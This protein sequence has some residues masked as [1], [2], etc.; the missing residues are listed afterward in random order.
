M[1]REIHQL[2]EGYIT[3]FIVINFRGI[4][5]EARLN[6]MTEKLNNDK[7]LARELEDKKIAAASALVGPKF[8]KN[9]EIV[10]A[11]NALLLDVVGYFRQGGNQQLIFNR[12]HERNLKPTEFELTFYLNGKEYRYGVYRTASRV[13]EEWLFERD[14][15][16]DAAHN[17]VCIFY[18]DK[19]KFVSELKGEAYDA[20]VS[21]LSRAHKDQLALTVIGRRNYNPYY[22]VFKWFLDIAQL[23]YIPDKMSRWNNPIFSAMAL[24]NH[25]ELKEFV[26]QIL[27]GYDC[28]IVDLEPVKESTEDNSK[29]IYDIVLTYSSDSRDSGDYKKVRVSNSSA[30]VNEV[31]VLALQV[32]LTQRMNIPVMIKFTQNNYD[33]GV[34]RRIIGSLSDRPG[35]LIFTLENDTSIKG[36]VISPGLVYNCDYDSKNVLFRRVG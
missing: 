6:L 31:I 5:G 12:K 30:G 3:N 21:V 17:E 22:F 9:T 28:C 26:L 18:R 1:I 16:K 24:Y 29:S 15:G 27:K 2:N 14:Y 19:G 13:L 7:M 20:L 11:F 36:G 34:L 32:N 4:E 33:L 25:P 23:Q 8:S 35:Q 10:D